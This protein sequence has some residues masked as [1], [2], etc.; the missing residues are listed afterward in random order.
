M[1]T[2]ELSIEIRRPVEAVF[3]FASDFRKIPQWQKSIKEAPVTPDRPPAVG[4]KGRQE[5]SFLGVKV[6]AT[7]EITALESNRS[8]SFKASSGPASMEAIWRFEAVGAGTRISGTYQVEPGGLFKL[9]GPLFASQAK[10][11]LEADW[12]RLKEVLEAQ[13]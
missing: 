6:E 12:Q 4:T 7:S 9:A 11:Q 1:L 3:A 8:L 5:G 2:I 13:G 10:K